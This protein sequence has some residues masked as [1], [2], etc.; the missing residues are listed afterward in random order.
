M[1]PYESFETD[2]D[3]TVYTEPSYK[4]EA[5]GSVGG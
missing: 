3:E 2:F 1:L 5:W 4:N